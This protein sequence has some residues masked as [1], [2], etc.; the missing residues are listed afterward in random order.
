M[1]RI[2]GEDVQDLDRIRRSGILRIELDLGEMFSVVENVERRNFSRNDRVHN[3][4]QQ[5]RAEFVNPEIQ[6][7]FLFY[8]KNIL[9]HILK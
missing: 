9:S 7:Q 1:G 3:F 5:F 8:S 4:E 6:F 2:P